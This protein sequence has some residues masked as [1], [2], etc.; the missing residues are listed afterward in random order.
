MLTLIEKDIKLVGNY[1]WMSLIMLVIIPVFLSRQSGGHYSGIYIL[2]MMLNFST[3]FIFSN[4]FMNEDKYKGNVY[5]LALP[6][7]SKQIV[8]A[9]YALAILSYIC[10]L[11]CYIGLYLFNVLF[12]GLSYSDISITFFLY[13]LTLDVIFP[14]Y[15]KF[16]YAKIKSL[17]LIIMIIL[18][19]WGLVLLKYIL[20]VEMVYEKIEIGISGGILVN[21][22]SIVF[23]LCSILI[24]VKALNR[25]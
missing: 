19:T 6:F 20:N 11:I 23:M 21:I 13:T 15:F 12:S 3:Y 22:L 14:L 25:N 1:F 10:V 17:L 18:P 4:I 16:S 5:M 2:M 24:S 7:G 8:L 9:K